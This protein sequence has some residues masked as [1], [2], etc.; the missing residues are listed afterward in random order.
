MFE[1]GM[2]DLPGFLAKHQVHVVASLPCYQAANVEKQRGKGA[3]D[4]SVEALRRLNAVGF[5]LPGGEHN[6]TL[7]YNPVGASLPPAQKGLE[8]RYRDELL[9]LFGIH[10]TNLITITNMPI[11]RFRHALEREGLTEAYQSLLIDNFSDHT[12]A[13][14]M[15]RTLVSVGWEGTL[16]DCDFNQMLEMPLPAGP[17][18]IWDV[19]DLASLDGQP[20]ATD[21]HCFGCT[22]GSGSSCSGALG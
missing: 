14:V 7:V 20:I 8:D 3:F 15:C 6:L 1:S 10:F 2:D 18:T 21:A 11:S 9:A 16:Y 17:R 12:T 4:K 19:D 22:A 13:H 5:G